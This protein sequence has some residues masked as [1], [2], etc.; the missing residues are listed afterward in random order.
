MSGARLL[1]AV[2]APSLL[3]RN[4]H[5]R[6]GSGLLDHGGRPAW[7]LHGM[8]RQILDAIDRFAP[9]AVL[10]GLDDRR[11]SVR[12]QAY[13]A[14][15]AGRAEKDP[16]LVDQLERAAALLDA[17]GMLTVTPDGLEADDVNASA[18]TWAER[19]GW[20]CVLITSD[21]DAFAHISEH[22]QVL[23]LITGGINGSPLLN[24]GRLRAM[25]GIAAEHY[26]EYAALR[27]DPSDN[28]PGV[29]G[30]GE[31]IA[32][33]LLSEMGSMRAVWADIDH[34]GG[35]TLVAT[36]DSYCAEVGRPRIGSAVLKRLATP[37][38]R[39]RFEFNLAIMSG[40]TDLDLGL[41]P[42]VPGSP[43][44]L[45]LHPDRVSRVVGHLGVPAT[46]QLALRVLTEPPAS[47]GR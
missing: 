21:R 11:T 38:A 24:P 2:D 3:H 37:A 20:S 22:T 13:P 26:L 31:K 25:Y 33:F 42:D 27:G 29:P 8:L 45:P 28:L 46:T 15:K 6:V 19:H 10:F 1:L 16:A 35:A 7:A 9:D 40:R 17:L 43:G 39:E 14:Y 23:R 36:L 47:T 32:P 18:A 12:E 30:I 5:A 34:C 41:T 4:H 44:L